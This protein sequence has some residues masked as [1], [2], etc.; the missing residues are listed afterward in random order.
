MDTPKSTNSFHAFSF[1]I[2]AQREKHTLLRKAAK[3]KRRRGIS[4]SADGDEDSAS[5]TAPPFRKGGRKLS[6]QRKPVSFYSV[7]MNRILYWCVIESQT[8]PV[9]T[10]VGE[11]ALQR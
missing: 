7:V 2:E 10:P 4:P 5:S 8:A 1:T 6:L 11:K 9:T 3:R